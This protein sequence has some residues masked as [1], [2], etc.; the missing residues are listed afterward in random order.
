MTGQKRLQKA[1]ANPSDFQGEGGDLEH[2]RH[3]PGSGRWRCQRATLLGPA[4]ARLSRSQ[5]RGA[6]RSPGLELYAARAKARLSV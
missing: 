2:V 6:G 3:E 1:F 5:R 4:R